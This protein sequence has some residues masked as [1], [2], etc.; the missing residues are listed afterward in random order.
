M[1]EKSRRKKE[2]IWVGGLCSLQNDVVLLVQNDVVLLSEF[3]SS[4]DADDRS[5]DHC[6]NDMSFAVYVLHARERTLAH[7]DDTLF[8][9]STERHFV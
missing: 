7:A 1:E 8:L 2:K 5:S 9:L 3:L 4:A 6:A